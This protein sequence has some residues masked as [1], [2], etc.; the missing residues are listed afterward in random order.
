MHIAPRLEGRLSG[1]VVGIAVG[2]FLLLVAV[3]GPYFR[4]FDEAKYLGIGYSMLAGHG[5]RT[6]FGAVFTPHSP[7]WPMVL[8]APDVWFGIDPFGWGQLVDA[9]AGAGVLLLVGW[10]GAQIRPLVGALAVVAYLATPYFQD[11]TR[12]ARLDV[13]AAFLVL[14]YLALG[15]TAV[16]RDSVARAIG[17]GVIIAVAFL[18]KEIVLPVAPV[19]FLVAILIGRPFATIARLAAATA[20]VAAAGTAW[21]FVLFASYTHQI[22]RLGAS[23]RLLLPLYLGVGVVVAVGLAAPWLATRASVRRVRDRLTRATPAR[24]SDRSRQLIA[25]GLATAWFLAF[26]VFFDRNP[27]LKGVGLVSLGQY[28]LYLETWLPSAGLP[29]VA[30]AGIGLI[31]AFVARQGLGKR[32]ATWFDATVLSLVCS[33]PLVML[34]VAVGEPPRNYLAQIGLL[35]VLAATGWVA[36]ARVVARQRRSPALVVALVAVGALAFAY[37]ARLSGEVPTVVGAIA[38]AALGLLLAWRW[39]P[40]DWGPLDPDT[41][42][43]ADAAT[44]AEPSTAATTTPRA[45]RPLATA[46]AALLVVALV[47]ASGALAVHALRTRQGPPGSSQA[48]AVAATAAWIQANVPPGA[49]IGFG[50]YLGYETAVEI[51]GRNPMVQIHQA[52]AVVDPSAPLGLAMF[53]QPPIDDWIAVDVS[54]REREFYVFR[55]ADFARS[56]RSTN[57]AYYVYLTGPNTSVPALLAAL[58]P[59]HGF[60]PVSSASF[61]S[62]SASGGRSVAGLSVFAVDPAKVDFSGAGMALSPDAL[63]RLTTLLAADPATAPATATALIARSVTYPEPSA[64]AAFL[65]RLRAKAGS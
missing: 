14:F 13:P 1:Q 6:V 19:P 42:T 29:L 10:F 17:A 59:E 20:L 9:I 39:V 45:S 3:A 63:D 5:P 62:V 25:W 52:L 44:P 53:G 48:Q 4:S 21:W 18:V 61:E 43:G 58:T 28:R 51:A 35:L 40:S 41:E 38:G 34:V 30:I 54:R 32:A 65:D 16:R 33:G 60:T 46:P 23:D 12:T 57:I 49:K 47:L 55:A 27:E 56:V 36:V 64:A 7:L 22:Y 15:M 26:V 24:V 37:L 11:L 2:A 31:S 50:S 8:A